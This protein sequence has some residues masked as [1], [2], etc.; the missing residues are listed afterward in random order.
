MTEIKQVTYDDL[1]EAE[2]RVLEA[3]MRAIQ[4]ERLVY[5]PGAWRCAKCKFTLIQSNLNA[6]DGTVTARDDP[7]DKCPNDGAPLWRVSY[8]D[9]CAEQSE[10]A[11][12]HIER[13]RAQI[14]DLQ[15]ALAG[16]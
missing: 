8:R 4:L 9:W 16:A 12:A 11:E 2:T 10:L 13:Q 6:Q 1:V 15:Q 14:A 5:V 7:G 3:E